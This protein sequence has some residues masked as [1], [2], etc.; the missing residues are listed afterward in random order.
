MIYHL[1]P[2]SPVRVRGNA[3]HGAVQLPLSTHDTQVYE[4][5]DEVRAVVCNLLSLTISVSN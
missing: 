4:D 2:L 5:V 3:W 1:K